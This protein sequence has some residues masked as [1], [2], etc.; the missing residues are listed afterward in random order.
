MP[1]NFLGRFVLLLLC[2]QAFLL[3]QIDTNRTLLDIRRK[4]ADSI[5][6]LPNYL[7]TETVERQT[8]MFKYADHAASFKSCGEVTATADKYQEAKMHLAAADRLRLDV[9]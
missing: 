6:R 3:A 4:V 7:C 9:A 5:S 8:F 1:L 2:S